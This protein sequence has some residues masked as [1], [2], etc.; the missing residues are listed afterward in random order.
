MP[1]SSA[2]QY[3]YQEIQQPDERLQSLICVVPGIKSKN[4]M[5]GVDKAGIES[6]L[7]DDKFTL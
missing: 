6:Y 5:S 2:R 1:N 4:A 3:F 7:I